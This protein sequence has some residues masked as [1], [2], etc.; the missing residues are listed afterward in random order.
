LESTLIRE[1]PGKST[2]ISSKLAEVD[3]EIS[4]HFGTSNSILDNVIFYHQEESTWPLSEPKV[5]K[6]KLDEIFDSTRYLKAHK[7]FKDSK[8]TIGSDIKLKE[9]GLLFL[10]KEK[11]KRD[12]LLRTK[13]SLEDSITAKKSLKKNIQK[14]ITEYQILS[15]NY[16]RKF[17]F[18]KSL[19]KTTKFSK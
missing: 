17:Q 11:T 3:K 6:D 7:G 8:R 19:N 4:E 2:I 16:N 1:F 9:Q 12:E 10:Y 5:L 14:N 15:K 18:M 13:N